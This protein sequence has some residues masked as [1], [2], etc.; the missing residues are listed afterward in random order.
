MPTAAKREVL[1]SSHVSRV[2]SSGT[3]MP[4]ARGIIGRNIKKN[5]SNGQPSYDEALFKDPPAK[6][7]CP[8]CFLP[9]PEELIACISLPPAT[10]SSVPIYDY[11]EAMRRWQNWI[12][13]NIIRVAGRVFVEGAYTPS[14]CLEMLRIVHIVEQG[15]REKQ[16]KKQSKN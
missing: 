4:I 9:M 13:K 15:E 16:M 14:E 5:A 2:C 3:A 11:A 7:D 1:V 8:I 6:D 10:I 12:W